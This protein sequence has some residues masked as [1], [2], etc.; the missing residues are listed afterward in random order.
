MKLLLDDTMNV[1]MKNVN[2]MIKENFQFHQ[3][4]E[5]SRAL[6]YR[7]LCWN[8]VSELNAKGATAPGGTRTRWHL[9]TAPLWC[10]IRRNPWWESQS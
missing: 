7:S 3:G 1:A 6:E 4:A 5:S 9:Q 10:E 2:E 8:Q